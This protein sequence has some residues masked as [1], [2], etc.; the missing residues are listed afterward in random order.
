MEKLILQSN[1]KDPS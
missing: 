1:K